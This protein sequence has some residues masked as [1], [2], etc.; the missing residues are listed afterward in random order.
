MTR[1]AAIALPWLDSGAGWLVFLCQKPPSLWLTPHLS[2]LFPQD[3]APYSRAIEELRQISAYLS[4]TPKLDC[5][6]RLSKSIVQCI[7]QYYEAQGHPA[8]SVDIGV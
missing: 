7:D 4:P 6:V 8:G 1:S 5:L 2:L 3:Q